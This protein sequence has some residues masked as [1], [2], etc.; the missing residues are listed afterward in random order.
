[1]TATHN[2]IC[3]SAFKTELKS[4]PLYHVAKKPNDHHSSVGR[5]D[6]QAS[7]SRAAP[8]PLFSC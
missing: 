6:K 5:E 4:Y 3:I 8:N 2:L 1:M 7:N